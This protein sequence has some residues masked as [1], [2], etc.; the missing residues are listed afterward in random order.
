MGTLSCVKTESVARSSIGKTY[1]TSYYSDQYG[2]VRMEN[3]NIDGSRL[4]VD[5][6]EVKR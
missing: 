5:L 2:F 4:V 3:T 6:V 1:L